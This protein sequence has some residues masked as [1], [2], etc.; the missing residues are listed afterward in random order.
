MKLE[1]WSLTDVGNVR[2]HNEDSLY[3][4]L[5]H[6]VFVVADGVGGS[7]A[8]EVASEILV[9]RVEERAAEVAELV[10]SGDPVKDRDHREKVFAFLLELVKDAND[11]VFHLGKELNPNLPSATTCDIVVI[12]DGAAFIAHVGDS[13]VYLF[14]D[15]EIFRITEDHTFSEQLRQENISNERMLDRYKNVLT[16]SIGG[17]PQV[18]VDALFIDLRPG[19]RV[20]MC[21]D[22]LTDYLTGPEILDYAGEHDGSELLNELVDEA[23]ARGG[24]DN[25]TSVLVSVEGLTVEQETPREGFDTLK[26]VDILGQISVFKGLNLRELIRVLRIVYEQSAVDGQEIMLDGDRG[27][28]MFIIADGEV[29][30]VEGDRTT[31]LQAGE[32]FGTFALVRPGSPRWASARSV[33]RSL[34][35]VVPASRFRDLIEAD[36]TLGNKLLWNLLGSAADHIERVMTDS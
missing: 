31:R 5:E 9:E 11:E 16:R 24:H 19:D 10:R 6:H 30:L 8:G 33:G 28:N 12:T 14:R 25:I 13:R 26:Q 1:A 22:G 35:L 7:E 27:E 15:Q 36:P 34:L 21:S 4:D 20:L 17:K 2:D 32:N 18:D 29:D 23:K 3:V